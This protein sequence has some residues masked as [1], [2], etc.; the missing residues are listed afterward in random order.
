VQLS[1]AV[2]AN[3]TTA[4][5][6]PWLELVTIFAG[7]VILGGIASFTVTLNEQRLVLPLVSVATQITVVTPLLKYELLAGLQTIVAPLQL[8]VAEGKKVTRARHWL[9]SALVT[10]SPGQMI[11]GFSAS[12][13][14][15]RN[16]QLIELLL[17]SR[18]A[19]V[20]KFVPL[21]NV[22]PEGG[23]Q[24]TFTL[25]QLSDT[26][27]AKLTTAS[28]RPVAV[29]TSMSAGHC[30]AG[31]SMSRTVTANWQVPT[32]E[33]LSEAEQLTMLEPTGK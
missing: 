28:Q 27:G 10:I 22:V 20:T 3:C 29:L 16:V 13:T 33:K 25:E 15:T 1:E 7:H 17:R 14:T 21:G 9:G 2:G 26:C 11:C 8:S 32:F 4:E 19:Q 31:D 18:A 24:V 12:R 6:C 5:R 23:A 30:R